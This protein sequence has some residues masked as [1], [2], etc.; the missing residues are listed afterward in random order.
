MT[1]DWRDRSSRSPLTV[2]PVF[3]FSFDCV[4][5]VVGAV[6]VIV[7]CEY[8]R[9]PELRLAVG[10]AE[11]WRHHANHQVGIVVQHD[12]ASEHV[13]VRAERR[14]PQRV[15]EDH[16]WGRAFAVFAVGKDTTERSPDAKRREQVGADRRAADAL[17]F[18]SAHQ[19]RPIV[20][21]D[22]N[23]LE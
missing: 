12:L 8:Q 5:L 22:P 15:A 13:R 16:G 2:A 10:K 20:P 6:L 17:R 1:R 11:G 23:A 9:D 19:V 4:E 7:G 21:V 18:T 14:P 3:S